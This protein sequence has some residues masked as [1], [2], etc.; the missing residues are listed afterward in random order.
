MAN[1]SY[2]QY[3]S[4]PTRYKDA[5]ARRSAADTALDIFAKS[6]YTHALRSAADVPIEILMNTA[7]GATGLYNVDERNIK[8]AAGSNDYNRRP[9]EIL[10][11]IIH[12]STHANQ[13]DPAGDAKPRD[14]GAERSMQHVASATGYYREEQSKLLDEFR[15]LEVNYSGGELPAWLNAALNPEVIKLNGGVIKSGNEQ[16]DNFISKYPEFSREYAR[17]TAF[18]N[19]PLTKHF[20]PVFPEE[21]PL[22]RRLVDSVMYGEEGKEIKLN[23]RK[24]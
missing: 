1:I 22:W 14:F 11:S 8:V 12:E 23:Q 3:L 18:P 7:K 24:E 6:S 20:E 13:F 9:A 2:D 16:L 5:E 4:D 19:R 17:R 21:K 10:A 15:A